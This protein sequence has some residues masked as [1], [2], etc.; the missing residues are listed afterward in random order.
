MTESEEF[1]KTVGEMV[2]KFARDI[3]EHTDC[4][5]ILVSKYSPNGDGNT[6]T[7]EFGVGNHNARYGQAVEWV[8][9]QREFHRHWARKSADEREEE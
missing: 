5:Q 1:Q 2:R 8:E 4:V 7:Y 3:S 9:I 6:L